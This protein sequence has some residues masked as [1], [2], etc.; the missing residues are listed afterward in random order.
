M[1]T[2]Q[3][4]YYRE[5]SAEDIRFIYGLVGIFSAVIFIADLVYLVW[6]K[7]ALKIDVE[8]FSDN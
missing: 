1:S 3:I 5:I 6:G 2:P 8:T 7:F 4:E